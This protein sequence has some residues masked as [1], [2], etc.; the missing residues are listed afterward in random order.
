MSTFTRQVDCSVVIPVY[1]KEATVVRAIESVLAQTVCP[2]EVIVV[3][4]ASTDSTKQVLEGLSHIE[5]LKVVHLPRNTGVSSARNLGVDIASAQWVA[6]LDADDFWEVG[7]L[8][9]C[10][11]CTSAG[12]S[13]VG[14]AYS[15]LA[16]S[17]CIAGR[18]PLADTIVSP[19]NDYFM[20]AVSGDLPF[21]A[22][23]VVVHR[24][25]FV[26]FGGFPPELSMGED[27]VVWL[28]LLKVGSGVFIDKPLASYDLTS[29]SA[30]S[31]L[32]HRLSDPVYLDYMLGLGAESNH[33]KRYVTR[34]MR[35]SLAYQCAYKSGLGVRS[36]LANPKARY[37]NRVEFL[38]F[39][40]ASWLPGFVRFPILRHLIKT[41][42]QK[43]A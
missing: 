32:T 11:Q 31:G 2:R 12:V 28:G 5:N 24:E 35:G 10:C 8:S 33:L 19:V 26:Q 20:W 23:S 36:S 39:Y 41:L 42:N 25:R 29:S 40:L 38:F 13:I 16:K 43:W 27:Q 1:N 3:N 6:F 37:L 34:V 22:S 17:G 4:D 30:V 7:F 15:Y 9:E 21:T 18:F 14:T